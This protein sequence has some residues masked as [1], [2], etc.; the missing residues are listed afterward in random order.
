ML[1][2]FIGVGHMGSELLNAVRAAGVKTIACEHRE[3][4][5]ATALE[6]AQKSFH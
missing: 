1:V 3:N 5:S 6:V 2:G 4:P